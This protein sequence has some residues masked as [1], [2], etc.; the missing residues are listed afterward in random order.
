MG[1]KA[2]GNRAT[3]LTGAVLSMTGAGLIDAFHAAAIVAAI[4]A[5]AAGLASFF[6]LEGRKPG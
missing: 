3:A 1:G 2:S 6:T 5:V 4:F